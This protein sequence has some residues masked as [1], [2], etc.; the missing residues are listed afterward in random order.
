MP[1][2]W[3]PVPLHV[4]TAGAATFWYVV[5]AVAMTWPLAAGLGRDIPWDLGDPLLNCWI[6]AHDAERMLAALTRGPSALAGF[7]TAGIFRPEPR[8]LAY[9]EALI[10]QALQILPVWALTRNPILCYN[11]LFLSTFVLSGLGVYLWLRDLT[12]DTRAAFVAGTLYAFALYRVGQFAHLQVLSSQWMPFAL[13]AFRRYFETGRP[14]ALAGAGLALW[15]QVLSCG[16]YLFYF[17]PFA[18]AYLWWEL[19]DRG[20]WRDRRT[21][22]A[23]GLTVAGAIAATMPFLLPYLE[24]R[25]Q[26]VT[27]RPS[28]EVVALS[29]DVYSYLSTRPELRIWGERAQAFPKPEGELFPGVIPPLLAAIGIGAWLRR[30]WRRSAAADPPWPRWTG[31]ASGLALAAFL[32]YMA[33]SLT[34]LVHGRIVSDLGPGFRLTSLWRL[35]EFMLAAGAVLLVLSPRARRFARGVPGSMVGFAFCATAAA[36]LLSLGPRVRAMGR[37]LGDGPYELLFWLVPGI[38]A[39]RVPARFGMIVLLFLAVLA[40]YGA[41]A[42]GRWR[43]RAGPAAVWLACGLFLAEATVVPIQVNVRLAT[44]GVRLTPPGPMRQGPDLPPVYR[45]VAELDEAALIEFPFGEPAFELQYMFYAIA[46][47]KPLVNGYSG[48][49]PPRYAE[50][51]ATFRRLPLLDPDAAWRILLGAGATHAVVHA[52]A[53]WEDEGHELA[54]WLKAH[55]ARLVGRFGD[56]RLFALPGPL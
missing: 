19:V 36:F 35:V 51:R 10:P 42:L 31:W 30:T 24:L 53:F 25:A 46:H 39:M 8:T 1:R 56:D 6:L 40:G 33:A 13:L 48:F 34:I 23:V 49:E 18:G 54:A 9:S 22:G 26:G 5:L 11:L 20:R 14:R 43:R 17:A 27:T 37:G 15:A 12:G 45:A 28:A 32:V 55:G 16:Y 41:A 4:R 21:L 38:E 44:R 2:V 3:S 29:A 7:W 52:G 50:L 47:G